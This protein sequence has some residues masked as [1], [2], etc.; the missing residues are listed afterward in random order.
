MNL[1]DRF[2]II[3]GKLEV[4]KNSKEEY[5][6]R[7]VN[8][9]QNILNLDLAIQILYNFNVW[10]N[11]QTKV[12]LENITNEALR[13]IFPDKD[14]KFHVVPNQT[15]KGVSYELTIE[16]D[17]IETDLLDAKGGGVLDVIQT[18]LRITYMLRLK[19]KVRP[20][21]IFDE[22][23]KNLDSERINSAVEWL[24]RISELF[25]IQM[26]I[27]THIPSMIIPNKNL[28]SYEMRLKGGISEIVKCS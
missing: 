3:K 9:E 22:P 15:K 10:I 5:E 14:M 7:I 2:N 17:G 20:L 25:G 21:I 11:E 8:S 13:L 6:N 27:I 24:T 19:S 23:F 4:L 26:F 12:K 18:C 28:V 1:K 16:T